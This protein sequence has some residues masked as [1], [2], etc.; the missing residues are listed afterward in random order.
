MLLHSR[1]WI[2]ILTRLFTPPRIFANYAKESIAIT[3][4][5]LG[6]ILFVNI[7]FFTIVAAIHLGIMFYVILKLPYERKLQTILLG[8]STIPFTAYFLCGL[9]R[10][11]IALA[12]RLPVK[13]SISLRGDKQYFQML[14]LCLSYYSLYVMLFKVA[15]SLDDY[16]GIVNEGIIKI[17]VIVGVIFFFWL[18]IR[19]IYSPFF[20]V[21]QEQSMRQ[22]IKSSLLL[23][24]G[25]TIRTSILIFFIALAFASGALAFI[26]GAFISFAL[27]TVAMILSY[28]IRLKNKYS[29]RKKIINQAAIKTRQDITGI[30]IIPKVLGDE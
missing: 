26:V 16:D 14:F 21:D 25:M 3:R 23:T 11:Y 17:R 19:L 30:H 5:S 9:L 12:R 29:R 8:Y 22:A 6:Q 24:S 18:F 13:A 28:D 20:I 4:K 27:A 2:K 7:T 10:Y 1:S 15:L